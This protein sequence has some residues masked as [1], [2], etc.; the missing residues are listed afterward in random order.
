MP[1]SETVLL[2]RELVAVIR[3]LDA[4]KAK[5]AKDEGDT[6]LEIAGLRGGNDRPNVAA[7]PHA[8]CCGGKA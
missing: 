7:A 6:R 1:D 4:L 5:Y 2:R 3:C 8:C